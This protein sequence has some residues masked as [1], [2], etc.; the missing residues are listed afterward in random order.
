MNHIESTK[1]LNLFI[2]WLLSHKPK[3][4]H[5]KAWGRKEC[6][7]LDFLTHLVILVTITIHSFVDLHIP[8]AFKEYLNMSSYIQGTL[9]KT[10]CERKT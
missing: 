3:D 2:Q 5:I 8:Q 9:G 10:E 6:G 4:N 1:L 7:F